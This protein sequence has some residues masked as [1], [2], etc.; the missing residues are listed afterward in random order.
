MKALNGLVISGMLTAF[1]LAGQQQPYFD[2]PTFVPSG[3]TD[4]ASR[5][6]HGSDPVLQSTESLARATAALTEASPAE[7]A[8]DALGALRGYQSAVERDP[9]EQHL[10]DLG[11]ELLKHRA[12]EQAIEVFTR[13]NRSFPQSSRMLLGLA[14]ARY[15]LGSFEEARDLFFQAA[16]LAPADPTP[17]LFLGKVQGAAITQ[18]PGFASRMERFAKLHPEN[19]S[20]NYFYAITLPKVPRARALLEKSVRLD[21][22]LS[23]AWLQLGV[24]WADANDYKKAISAWKRAIEADPH[25]AEAHYRLSQA[26]RRMGDRVNAQKEIELYEKVSKESEEELERQR[27]AIKQFVF[28][29]K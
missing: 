3:V 10:F 16:D 23:G 4:P 27:S 15:S 18:S 24:A 2:P 6:G 28:D 7:K 17:Y 9:G 1:A 19:A 26:Y 29:L 12:A 21:S 22:Q 25:L 20:A 5:G 8:G 14:V 13:G 11:A